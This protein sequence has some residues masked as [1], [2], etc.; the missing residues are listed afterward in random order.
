MKPVL[1]LL[2]KLGKK[3]QTLE[4]SVEKIQKGDK[5]LQNDLIQQYKPF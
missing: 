5:D 1:S 4:T 2:F 3:K